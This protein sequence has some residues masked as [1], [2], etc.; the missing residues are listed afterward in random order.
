MFGYRSIGR[1]HSA[2][3]PT[4]IVMIAITLAKIGR[5]MKNRESMERYY[6]TALR[7]RGLAGKNLSVRVRKNASQLDRSRTFVDGRV[8]IIDMTAMLIIGTTA[9]RELNRNLSFS[10]SL[11]QHARRFAKVQKIVSADRGINVNRI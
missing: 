7:L 3:P 9:E 8:V 2:T 5:W 1:P 11:A 4:I 10:A 6:C